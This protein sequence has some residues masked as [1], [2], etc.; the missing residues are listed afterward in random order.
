[1]RMY[2]A[3]KFTYAKELA[4]RMT[5][6]SFS[7]RAITCT[8]NGERHGINETEEDEKIIIFQIG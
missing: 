6:L 4:S 7:S 1:M 3:E 8:V 2:C 5:A